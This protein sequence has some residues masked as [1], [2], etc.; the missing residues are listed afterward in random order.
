VRTLKSGGIPE[1][2]GLSRYTRRIAE[3]WQRLGG[4][5]YLGKGVAA[6]FI[7]ATVVLLLGLE[8][9]TIRDAVLSGF[10]WESLVGR[11]SE[12]SDK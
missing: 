6:T 8:F 2:K 11:V 12:P 10:A 3:V 9:Y 1:S 4:N 7:A 5:R